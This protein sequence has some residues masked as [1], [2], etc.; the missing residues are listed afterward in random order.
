V[1]A[2]DGPQRAELHQ[3]AAEL[4]LGE[5]VEF[6]GNVSDVPSVLAGA[7]VYVQPSYQ[8]GMPNS[9]LEAMAC[10]LPVVATRVSGNV[11]LVEEGESGLLVPPGD[12]AALAQ[13]LAALL[14]AP[15]R[16]LA[17]GLRSRAIVERRFSV[18][19]VLQQLLSAY[20]RPRRAA[21]DPR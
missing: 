11:D 3:L 8:E 14:A 18:P 9:V 1:I 12:D 10:A 7:S 19:S 16:A 6:M 15:E 21:T 20:H 2:G 5:H 17:M 4:R 13:A